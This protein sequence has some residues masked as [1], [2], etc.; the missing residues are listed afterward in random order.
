MKA[1]ISINSIEELEREALNAIEIYEDR[2]E[3]LDSDDDEE[4][5][6]NDDLFMDDPG[7]VVL[8]T[9]EIEIE[10]DFP[11]DEF[12]SVLSFSVDLLNRGEDE[13]L[14]DIGNLDSKHIA[15]ITLLLR[16]KWTDPAGKSMAVYDV[17]LD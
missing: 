10:A 13:D 6:E 2:P 3:D 9:D 14:S 7:D 8:E 15:E 11:L 16:E 12:P 1:Y 5:E 17:D 4:D